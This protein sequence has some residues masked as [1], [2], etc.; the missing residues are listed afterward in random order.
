[1][2]IQG[3]DD[4]LVL[5]LGVGVEDKALEVVDAVGAELFVALLLDAQSCL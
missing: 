1:M 4:E 5:G 2:F 3:V